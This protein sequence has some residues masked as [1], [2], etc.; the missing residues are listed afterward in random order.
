MTS[1]CRITHTVKGVGL[2]FRVSGLGPLLL[3]GIIIGILIFRPLKRRGFINHGS[4]LMIRSVTLYVLI[5]E[6]HAPSSTLG[7]LLGLLCLLVVCRKYGRKSLCDIFPY[8]LY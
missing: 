8:S 6:G 4:T 1:I 3:M 2:G 7:R 5:S